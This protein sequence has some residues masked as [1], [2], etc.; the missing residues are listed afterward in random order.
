MFVV[1]FFLFFLFFF[2]F[3]FIFNEKYRGIY[4]PGAY[5]GTTAR[6]QCLAFLWY[7]HL[8]PVNKLHPASGWNLPKSARA[9]SRVHGQGSRALSQSVCLPSSACH[10]RHIWS[11]QS[12]PLSSVIFS[13]TYHPRGIGPC[14]TALSR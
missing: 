14:R 12:D 7:V 1:V 3:Y 8:L 11:L 13:L 4:T 5:V 6:T 9:W 10:F 2:T